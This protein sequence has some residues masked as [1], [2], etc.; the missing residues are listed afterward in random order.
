MENKL[1][2]L[3]YWMNKTGGRKNAAYTLWKRQIQ[4]DRRGGT[5]SMTPT[6]TRNIRVTNVASPR[7][8]PAAPKASGG[9]VDAGKVAATATSAALV[10]GASFGLARHIQNKERAMAKSAANSTR[11]QEANERKRRQ[12]SARKGVETKRAKAAERLTS[13]RAKAAAANPRAAGAA[14]QRVTSAQLKGDAPSAEARKYGGG[15]F[16]GN[17]MPPGRR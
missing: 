8:T 3:S 15:K 4:V 5:P 2:K 11:T 16:G 14:A 13:A 1:K 12:A 17:A 6:T 7:V 9:G 10:T